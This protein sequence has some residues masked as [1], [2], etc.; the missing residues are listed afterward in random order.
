MAPIITIAPSM[1]A[2]GQAKA[3]KLRGATT[4]ISISTRTMVTVEAIM[5]IMLAV[6]TMVLLALA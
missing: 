6:R 2:S 4:P 3:V 1:V 5:M